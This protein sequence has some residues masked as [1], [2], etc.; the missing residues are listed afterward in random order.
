MLSTDFTV[1]DCLVE[2]TRLLFTLPAEGSALQLAVLNVR[3][4]NSPLTDFKLQLKAGKELLEDSNHSLFYTVSPGSSVA[5]LNSIN[6]S[7]S[8]TQYPSRYTFG[9]TCSGCTLPSGNVIVSLELP[10]SGMANPVST[11]TLAYNSASY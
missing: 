3:N 4:P 1:T 10:D 8:F 9:L 6:L 2:D 7:T 11:F 5:L